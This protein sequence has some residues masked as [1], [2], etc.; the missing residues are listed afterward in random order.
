M[1][2]TF[3]GPP[4]GIIN[5]LKPAG[6]TSHDCVSFLRRI[7]KIR[8]IG[9][10]GTLDPMAAGVLPLCIGR[11]TRLVEY[12]ELDGKSYRCEMLFGLETDTLDIWGTVLEDRRAG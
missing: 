1:T 8:A 11:G 9:H 12:M 4:E 7:T 3:Q 6:M 2:A 5:L 10:A